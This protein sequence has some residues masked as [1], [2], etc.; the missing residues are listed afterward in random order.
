[1]NL[2]IVEFGQLGDE[3]LDFGG[4]LAQEVKDQGLAVE[5]MLDVHQDGRQTKL[6]QSGLAGVV[7]GLFVFQQTGFEQLVLDRHATEN[8]AVPFTG[9]AFFVGRSQH[10]ADLQA[11]V[12]ADDHPA[13]TRISGS[14]D[15]REPSHMP[16]GA[17]T[18]YMKSGHLANL[19]KRLFSKPLYSRR[20]ASACQ[21]LSRE[22]IDGNASASWQSVL[23][24]SEG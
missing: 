17:H 18:N 4:L 22:T 20:A 8:R 21:A 14:V 9:L 10:L 7:G 5:Q 1:L 6:V 11:A 12:G 15:G 13:A 19:R 24:P 16:Q 23:T 3:G 2:G